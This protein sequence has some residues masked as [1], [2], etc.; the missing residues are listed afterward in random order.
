MKKIILIILLC[1]ITGCY[2][3]VMKVKFIKKT[4]DNIEILTIK[5]K[6]ININDSKLIYSNLILFNKGKKFFLK[7]NNIQKEY[8][9]GLFFTDEFYELD[10]KYHYPPFTSYLTNT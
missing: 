6:Y 10:K 9:L 5:N 8:N 7:R 2:D 1:F 4:T 3:S